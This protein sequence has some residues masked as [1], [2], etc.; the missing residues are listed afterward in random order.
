MTACRLDESR[1]YVFWR[2]VLAGSESDEPLGRV[3]DGQAASRF[4]VMVQEP[5]RLRAWWRTARRS[6]CAESDTAGQ[7]SVKLSSLHSLS[8]S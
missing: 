1:R 4:E 3:V 7:R 2:Y 5:A 8:M 6:Q